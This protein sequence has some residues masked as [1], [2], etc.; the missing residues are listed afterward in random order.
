MTIELCKRSEQR[1]NLS[2]AAGRNLDSTT[3]HTPQTNNLKNEQPTVHLS[4]EQIVEGTAISHVAYNISA[5]FVAEST[6]RIQSNTARHSEVSLEPTQNC[7][8]N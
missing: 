6:H 8:A 1:A 7:F 5:V 3:E 4:D 2:R